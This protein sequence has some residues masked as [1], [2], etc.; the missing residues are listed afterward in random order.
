MSPRWKMDPGWLRRRERAAAARRLSGAAGDAIGAAEH[1]L[2]GAGAG[3]ESVVTDGA[4]QLSAEERAVAAHLVAGVER[5]VGQERALVERA[6]R[7]GDGAEDGRRLRDTVHA[8]LVPAGEDAGEG[9]EAPR[10]GVVRDGEHRAYPASRSRLG[11][12]GASVGVPVCV[13]RHSPAWP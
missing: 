6:Q 1:A 11:V 3:V 7:R 4:G 12:R 13:L 8:L 9:G 10:C 5:I 2:A